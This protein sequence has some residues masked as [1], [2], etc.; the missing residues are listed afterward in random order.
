MDRYF[1]LK[2]DRS[3]DASELH[4]I[5]TTCMFIA[6]KM[7][8]VTPLF[9]RQVVKQIGPGRFTMNGIRNREIDILNTLSFDLIFVTPIDFL[10]ALAANLDLSDVVYKT[11]QAICYLTAIYYDFLGC[12]PSQHAAIAVSLALVSSGLEPYIEPV[13]DALSFTAVDLIEVAF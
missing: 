4:E 13:F 10:D 1:K 8:D 6:S 3:L 12:T 5:G 11:A 9:L 7:L 2:T